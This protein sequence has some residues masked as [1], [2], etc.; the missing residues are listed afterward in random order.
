MLV[1]ELVEDLVVALVALVWT[2]KSD[3]INE[4]AKLVIIVVQFCDIYPEIIKKTSS[5]TKGFT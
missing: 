2:C 4:V 1:V 5:S 3:K